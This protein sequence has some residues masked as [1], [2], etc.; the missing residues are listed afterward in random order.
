[1]DGNMNEGQACHCRVT[2]LKL[3]VYPDVD[4][5]LYFKSNWDFNGS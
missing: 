1:M 2:P 5:E 3:S 4:F